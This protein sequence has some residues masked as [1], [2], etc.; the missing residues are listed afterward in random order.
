MKKYLIIIPV[1][2]IVAILLWLYLPALI[3]KPTQSSIPQKSIN[4]TPTILATDLDI[5]WE[6]IRLSNSELL[7]SQRSG[8]VILYNTSTD[9]SRTLYQSNALQGGEGGLL[10]MAL[11][12]DFNTTR[13]IYL[14]ETYYAKD[15]KLNR[16][17]QYR[18]EPDSL[19]FVRTI[20]DTIPGATYHDGG[21]IAFG[22]DQKLYV[23]TGDATQELIA[24]DLTS[25][26]GKI[27][28]LNEDGSIPDDNPFL[29]SFVFSYGHRNPQGLAWDSRNRLWS[30][31]H[32]PSGSESGHDEIN[33]I[34]AGANYGWPYY[35]GDKVRYETIPQNNS[36]VAPVLE[37]SEDETWAPA[38]L[39]ID[40][41]DTLYFTGLRGQSVYKASITDDSLV[42]L[43]RLFP[44]KYGRIRTVNIVEDSL[45]FSTSN[46]D[47][48]GIEKNGDDKIIS[49]TIQ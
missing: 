44:E 30:S 38:G 18:F 39:A 46:T 1:T 17:N 9:S 25:L 32:G 14:Y 43:T 35:A 27:L 41:D 47:G 13:L 2:S 22:P 23:A 20:L 5:P 42:S 31:E 4:E 12:P 37:S 6:F 36:Y 10:G 3:F 26:G 7:I 11:H 15:Q 34:V 28:R 33:L 19:V 29:N 49:L 45:L 21:R 24:Q 48:R 16:I 40:T 8:S